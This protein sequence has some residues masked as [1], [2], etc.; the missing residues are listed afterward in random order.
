MQAQAACAA[1][2]AVRFIEAHL[3]DALDLTGLAGALHYSKF[4]LHRQFSSTLGLSP[5]TYIRRRQLTEA[6][7]RLAFTGVPIVEVALSCGFQ[8]QQAFTAAFSAMYKQPPARFRA[9]GAFY[10]LLCPM[11]VAHAG[12]RLPFAQQ[13]V[14]CAT[15]GD[16]E[17]W[18]KL[19]SLSVSGYPCLNEP[20][21]RA[22]LR[23]AIAAREAF[24]LRDGERIVG[25]M[26][27]RAGAGW[28]DYLAV[29]PQ[30]RALGALEA[31]VRKAAELCAGAVSVTT[32]RAGD[33]ADAG[34]RERWLG[35]GF[36]P[37]DLMQ[38]FGY[39]T[40]RL[41]LPPKA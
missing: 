35:L 23:R 26:C 22:A 32:F 9:E 5:H 6:A 24:V 40:Q 8:S 4:H 39:P 21:Y 18:L 7:W 34:W 10:P 25:A 11:P 3:G 12:R 38:E 28:I 15:P 37:S 31:L 41:V 36:Q 16:T 20:A 13:D 30:Y 29:H 2:Q 17:G 1:A 14:V 33:R 19:L 27:C